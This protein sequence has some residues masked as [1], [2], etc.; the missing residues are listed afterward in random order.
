MILYRSK[1]LFRSFIKICSALLILMWLWNCI[2]QHAHTTTRGIMLSTCVKFAD[3]HCF[4]INAEKKTQL[5][6][7]YKF[8]HSVTASVNIAFLGNTL[9]LSNS[10]GHLSRTLTS[11]LSDDDDISNISKNMCCKANYLLH[12]FLLRPLVNTRL[13]S[14][15]CLSLY[16][17]VLNWD[18]LKCILTTFFGRS[19]LF[20]TIATLA[21]S[22]LIL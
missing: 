12:V 6:K 15:S 2:L 1:L 5:I 13:F 7:F 16:G 10:I 14:S 22:I 20:P 21:L 11:N 3:F 9:S 17:A 4:S 19:G 18:H 8:P